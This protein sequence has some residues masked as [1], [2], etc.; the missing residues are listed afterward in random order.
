[1]K[2]TNLKEVKDVLLEFSEESARVFLVDLEDKRK[3]LND[4]KK[5]GDP[6]GIISEAIEFEL[7][8]KKRIPNLKKEELLSPE[9]K[10]I[11]DS[12]SDLL[13]EKFLCSTLS[14]ESIN[15]INKRTVDLQ[16]EYSTGNKYSKKIDFKAGI[17]ENIVEFNFL[18]IYGN[19]VWGF[20]NDENEESTDKIISETKEKLV[21][22]MM[23]QFDD[24]LSEIEKEKPLEELMAIVNPGMSDDDYIKAVSDIDIFLKSDLSPKFI[25]NKKI[26]LNFLKTAIEKDSSNLTTLKNISGNLLRVIKLPKMNRDMMDSVIKWYVDDEIRRGLFSPVDPYNNK[27]VLSFELDLLSKLLNGYL[28]KEKAE[29]LG[30]LM[31]EEF[32]KNSNLSYIHTFKIEEEDAREIFSI[33][34]GMRLTKNDLLS[35]LSQNKFVAKDFVR[36]F[37]EVSNKKAVIG[38]EVKIVNIPKN[39]DLS[40][41][42]NLIS[43]ANNNEKFIINCGPDEKKN[44]KRSL[45]RLMLVSYKV[46]NSETIKDI[47]SCVEFD[48]ILFDI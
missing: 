9:L 16:L 28:N 35:I 29:K 38:S 47:L 21:D 19:L 18:D 41:Y 23:T 24:R 32:N 37:N 5:S 13:S 44:I 45:E 31:G 11:F 34:R 10:M 40:F 7:L 22:L 20:L 39:V 12:E 33:N 17:F 48:L 3:M 36:K 4:L 42:D 2:I 30:S 8:G 26:I 6:T 1:M 46:I 25:V 14:F 43:L 15:E 27:V